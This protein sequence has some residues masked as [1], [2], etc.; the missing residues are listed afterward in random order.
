MQAYVDGM[1]EL[2]LFTL[3]LRKQTWSKLMSALQQKRNAVMLVLSWQL[4]AAVTFLTANRY[5][6]VYNCGI[7]PT[8]DVRRQ[9]LFSQKLEA[10][11]GLTEASSAAAQLLQSSFCSNPVATRSLSPAC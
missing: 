3:N 9:H 2:Q 5:A 10:G 4:C 1:Q 6:S 7:H 11:F 8:S